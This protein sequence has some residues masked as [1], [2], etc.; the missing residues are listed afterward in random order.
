MLA[1]AAAVLTRF[2]L[3]ATA[4]GKTSPVRMVGGWHKGTLTS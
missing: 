2:A 3:I 4:E 1:A